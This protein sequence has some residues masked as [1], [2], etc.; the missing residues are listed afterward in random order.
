MES[1]K[2]PYTLE[3]QSCFGGKFV[4][5]TSS[6][7]SSSS[8]SSKRFTL[9][10]LQC[11]GCHSFLLLSISAFQ[12]LILWQP[13]PQPQP[14]PSL[15]IYSVPLIFWFLS[16]ISSKLKIIIV[17][18]LPY[19]YYYSI[20]LWRKMEFVDILFM[21]FFFKKKKEL[22]IIP[23][24]TLKRMFQSVNIYTNWAGGPKKKIENRLENLLR[25][26]FQNIGA[27]C[28]SP[29]FPKRTALNSKR[30]LISY[31]SFILGSSLRKLNVLHHCKF[32]EQLLFS[33]CATLGWT[34]GG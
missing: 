21:F 20:N 5:P 9:L 4:I 12:C 13:Q 34:C 10:R 1:L 7:S 3:L 29:T 2:L 15:P 33:F 31:L 30:Y 8:S 27:S 14:P 24:L 32:L 22:L 17:P 26:R 11:T 16:L 6:S 28:N 25:L 23:C 19:S 18:V